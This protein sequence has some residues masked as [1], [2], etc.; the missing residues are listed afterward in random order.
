MK[1][2][3]YTCIK[4]QQRAGDGANVFL[5]FHAKAGELYEWAAI[6]RYTA[7]KKDGPQRLPQKAKIAEVKRFFEQDSRNTIPTALLI[8]LSVP[9]GAMTQPYPERPEI[10]SLE[11][12]FDENANPLA[13][14]GMIVDGQHRLLGVIAF[15]PDLMLNVVVMVNVSDDETAFQFLVVNN[16]ASRVSSNHL[17]ALVHNYQEAALSKRLRDVRMSISQ[18]LDF[19]GLVDTEANSPFKGIIDW[20]NNQQEGQASKGFVPPNAIESC[21]AFIKQKRITELEDDAILL[22]FFLTIWTV[23]KAKWT[24]QFKK[25]T[26]LLEKVPIICLTQF[27]VENISHEYDNDKLDV[28]NFEQVADN[29]DRVTNSINPKLWEV[30]WSAKGLDTS[31]GRAMLIETLTEMRRNINAGRNWYDKISIIDLQSDLI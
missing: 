10:I 19:V 16:K 3:K 2:Y 13:Q 25:E 30:K 26:H 11:F 6:E 20:P 9:A 22:G 15:Q 17:R 29:V 21:I 24:N 18:N 5:L 14:P 31:A 23:V 1:H 7:D 28:T 4:N 8:S 27:L 12:N